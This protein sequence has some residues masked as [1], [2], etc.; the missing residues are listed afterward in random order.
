MPA[1][2]LAPAPGVAAGRET[3][4]KFQVPPARRAAVERALGTVTAERHT[5]RARYFDTADGRLAAAGLA[6]RLRQQDGRWRQT[7][8]ARGDGVWQRL[9]DEVLLPADAG[10]PPPIDPARHDGTEVGRQLRRALAG[11]GPL[12]LRHASEILR[13]TRVLRNAGARVEVALDVGTLE[14]GSRRRELVEL[15]FEF[16]GG[17][18]GTSSAAMLALAARWVDRFGL[19]L[20]PATKAARAGWLADGLSAPPVVM[21]VPTPVAADLPLAKARSVMVG[22]TLAHALPNAAALA[23]G[24]GAAGHVHQ[25][26]VALRRLRSVLHA[27]GPPDAARDAALRMLFTAL[28]TARDADVGP[29][30]LAPARAAAT[31]AGV[32]VPPP[33]AAAP[34]PE[35]GAIVAL[36]AAPASTRLWLDLLRLTIEGPAAPEPAA[37]ASSVN[38]ADSSADSLADPAQNW[39]AVAAPLLARWRR[40]ARRDAKAW[41]TLDTA[42]RHRL[43]RRLKRVRYLLEFSTLLWSAKA[44]RQDLRALKALQ[45][46]LGE[47]HDA[48]LAQATLAP[49]VPVDPAAAFVAGW[50]ARETVATE[51]RCAKAAARWARV[52]SPTLRTSV[53]ARLRQHRRTPR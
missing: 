20:D 34:A 2:A 41:P 1:I 23:G 32:V 26:R 39:A 43:R 47:W 51:R 25:L 4:L 15:E 31:A 14:V 17:V 52:K 35:T 13:V 44:L 7:L 8:K 10:D 37:P 29:A 28:G 18:A 42:G 22:A 50:L 3:E 19:W 16:L 6:W 12:E 24:D 46:R 40:Q 45:E 49:V 9:E 30:T 27:L 48:V 33:A 11:A 53:A 21:A 36:L 5:L 38:P